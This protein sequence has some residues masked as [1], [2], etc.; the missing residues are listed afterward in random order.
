M[1]N[2]IQIIP[3]FGEMQDKGSYKQQDAD[4]C[5]QSIL[6]V[7][8]PYATYEVYTSAD[9]DHLILIRIKKAIKKTLWTTFSELSLKLCN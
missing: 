4:E 6:D 5:F 2:L 8:S 3:H 7:V 9:Y 1:Q